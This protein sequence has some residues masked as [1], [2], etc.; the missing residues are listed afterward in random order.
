MYQ[1]HV[2]I[3][4]MELR[5]SWKAA[6]HPVTWEFPNI[7]WNRKVYYCVHKSPPL[8]PVLSQISAVHITSSCLLRSILILSS[9]LL[10][11]LHSGLLLAS[12]TQ[13]F[14]PMHATFHTHHILLDLIVLIILGKEYKFTNFSLCTFLQPPIILSIFNP[15]ILLS[16]LVSNTHN[17]CSPV[18]S[19]T[20]F[21][22][23]AKSQAKYYIFI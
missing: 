1:L 20:K 21:H 23:S 16:T 12:Y 18:M 7:L 11:G 13:F 2:I 19:E 8:V 15:N 17:L 14:L 9:H 6:T 10:L 4:S 22:T 5:S 3:N